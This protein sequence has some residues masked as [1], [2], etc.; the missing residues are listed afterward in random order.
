M[1]LTPAQFARELPQWYQIFVKNNNSYFRVEEMLTNKASKV[2]YLN[3]ADL[4]EITKVLGN[5]HNIRGRVQRANSE[6]TVMDATKRAILNL[7]NPVEAYKN[8]CGIKQWG[9]TYRTKTLRCVCPRNYAALDSKLRTCV[10][11]RYF[12]S[13]IEGKQYAEFI[14]FLKRVR[15]QV[16]ESGPRDGEWFVADVEMA[17]FQFAC[18]PNNRIKYTE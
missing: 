9:F 3:M 2:G 1:E 13:R 17:L 6:A 8:M 16:S 4:V 11:R 14:D 10:D 12:P 15:Q 18:N 7:D 5:P